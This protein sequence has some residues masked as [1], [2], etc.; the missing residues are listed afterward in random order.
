MTQEIFDDEPV[1]YY[2][3]KFN[4]AKFTL[5][6]EWA[7]DHT[8]IG[9]AP[10]MVVLGRWSKPHYDDDRDGDRFKEVTL[11]VESVRHLE[12]EARRSAI[13]YL[14]EGEMAD[15]ELPAS[16]AEQKLSKAMGQDTKLQAY[17]EENWSKDAEKGGT[18]VEVAI[19]LLREFEAFLREGG[20]GVETAVSGPPAAAVA[21]PV[22][23][24]PFV[25]LGPDEDD[26]P[27]NFSFGKFDEDDDP[28][29]RRVDLAT[30]E[31]IERVGTV[32]GA[33]H[34]GATEKILE[35]I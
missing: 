25:D 30:G 6:S 18:P 28:T 10:V 16:D 26:E 8:K 35:S 3:A 11:L 33:H 12:G 15:M 5:D 23:G 31:I 21:P 7:I 4:G 29:P 27:Q 2:R 14:Q 1:A 19:R 24:P 13:H 9:K 32:N 22:V 20:E 34:S 17:L